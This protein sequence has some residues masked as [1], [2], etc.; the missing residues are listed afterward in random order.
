MDTRAD[1]TAAN[2][3][4]AVHDR[5][6]RAAQSREPALCCPI[7]YDPEYLK[8]IPHEVI[9]RDYG[10]GDPSRYVMEGDAV[11]DLGSGGGK[12]CFVAAQIAG[13]KGHVIGID[14]NQAMLDL[15]RRAAPVVAER[16]GYANVRFHRARIQDLRLDV[17]RV[18]AWLRGQPVG[19]ASEL[20]AFE[21]W[22][23]R[24]R[25]N[26]PLVPD[27]SVDIALSNCVLN[28]VRE[29]DKSQLLA[30]I[31]RVLRRGGRIAISDIVSDQPVPDALKADP[32][33]WSGCVSGAFQE[34]ELLRQLEEVGFYGI[35]VEQWEVE[36]FRVV[37]GIEFRSLTLTARKGK[38]GPCFES[39]HAVVY[40]GPW[41]QVEDDDGHVLRRGERSAVCAETHRILS[42]PP[43]ADQ[44]VAI[45]PRGATASADPRH[46]S[47]CC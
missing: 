22:T 40:R 24:L 34:Q 18:D 30:E 28:L 19:D 29:C 35:A 14:M 27:E 32:E 45:E 1:S 43:Y 17:D 20:S 36:P 38:A 6:E 41:K 33:L 42:S 16:I 8:A 11:L 25:C 5:Y 3:E 39:D 7:E 47:S 31:F 10:C 26:D 15:A 13:P 4:R 46:D 12:S 37:D 2:I 21:E 44:I 23:D 9:E